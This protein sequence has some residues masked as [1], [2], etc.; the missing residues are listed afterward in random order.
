MITFPELAERLKQ[1]N[2]VDL[3]ELLDVSS[4]ELVERFQDRIEERY[5]ILVEEFDTD[6][7]N[8]YYAEEQE[9]A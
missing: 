1:V 9:G 3:L 8:P 4:E 2:E 5:E 7:W 6:E